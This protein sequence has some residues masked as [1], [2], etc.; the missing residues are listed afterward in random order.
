MRIPAREV[1]LATTAP[2]GLSLHNMLTA[3]VAAVH[4]EPASD[5]AI[6]Q[7]QVGDGDVRLLA[8]VTRDAVARLGL[9]PGAPVHALIK[10]VSID[11]AGGAQ[12]GS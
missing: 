7:L 5:R 6:V 8:E 1:I 10:S 12:P 3:T 9:A 2:A 4:A 11:V